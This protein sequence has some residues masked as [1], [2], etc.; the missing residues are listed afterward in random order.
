MSSLGNVNVDSCE[1]IELNSTINSDMDLLNQVTCNDLSVMNA[2]IKWAIPMSF[3]I[4]LAGAMFYY[5]VRK[6]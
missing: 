6:R 1:F 3:V 5:C 2:S 4:F